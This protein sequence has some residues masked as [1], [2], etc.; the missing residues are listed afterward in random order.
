MIYA[1]VVRVPKKVDI[2]G[3]NLGKYD[4]FFSK[5]RGHSHPDEE[6]VGFCLLLH[7]QRSTIDQTPLV[8]YT[9]TEFIEKISKPPFIVMDVAGCDDYRL[10]G[11][12]LLDDY[13]Y[14]ARMIPNQFLREEIENFNKQGQV[15]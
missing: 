8:L 5:K 7:I 1:S 4:H 13:K 3:I 15:K 14:F 6:I 9:S 11:T 10:L 12:N 2:D